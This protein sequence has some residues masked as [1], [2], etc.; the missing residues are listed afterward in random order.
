MSKCCMHNDRST[1]T[2]RRAWGLP[3][4]TDAAV[5]SVIAIIVKNA[6]FSL[7]RKELQRPCVTQAAEKLIWSNTSS[8]HSL[9]PFIYLFILFFFPFKQSDWPEGYHLASTM[10]FRFPQC[11]PISLKTLIPNASNEAIQLM[12]DM[13]NWNP[14]KRPTASQVWASW[15]AIISHFPHLIFITCLYGG[16]QWK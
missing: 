16:G 2:Y 7:Y 5:T 6:Y 9:H 10:N 15:I 13:L 11:V 8:M 3:L 1:L 4:E 12:T 14:K